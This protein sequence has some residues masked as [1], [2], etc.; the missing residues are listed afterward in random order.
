MTKRP[1]K[2]KAPTP[3][4]KYTKRNIKENDDTGGGDLQLFRIETYDG[5]FRQNGFRNTSDY[6]KLV[7]TIEKLQLREMFAIKK[8]WKNYPHKIVK[9]LQ[10]KMKIMIVKIPDNANHFRIVRTQ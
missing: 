7:S 6:K 8:E 3:K 10:L 4:R 1:A 5:N 9:E 2:K